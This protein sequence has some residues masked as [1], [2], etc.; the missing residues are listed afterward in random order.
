MSGKG[1]FYTISL[2]EYSWP[3]GRLYVGD[4]K[5]NKMHGN[6]VFKFAD[7]KIY[8]GEYADDKRHSYGVMKW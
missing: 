2:G 1:K 4:W 3:D 5:D 7:G 8:E 6:G